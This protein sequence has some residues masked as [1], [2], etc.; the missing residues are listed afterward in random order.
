MRDPEPHFLFVL[1][2]ILGCKCTPGKADRQDREIAE[3]SAAHDVIL[4]AVQFE[5]EGLAGL[6][7]T[8]L[9][10]AAGLPEINFVRSSTPREIGEP[11]VVRDSHVES[12]A[13]QPSGILPQKLPPCVPRLTFPVLCSSSIPV[14]HAPCRAVI[15][16]AKN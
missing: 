3:E 11:V 13:S 5:E 9:S 8:K 12:H 15:G 1:C 4:G 6:K 10:A 14:E 7:Y 16:L 2:P